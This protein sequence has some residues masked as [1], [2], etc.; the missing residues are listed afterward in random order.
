MLNGFLVL[1]LLRKVPR[2]FNNP[3]QSLPAS[4]LPFI[5]ACPEEVIRSL[6]WWDSGERARLPEVAGRKCHQFQ[7]LWNGIEVS[8]LPR[9][10]SEMRPA[11][12]MPRGPKPGIGRVAICPPLGVL[13]FCPPCV[14]RRL[15]T[16]VASF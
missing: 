16:W 8:P 14:A 1:Y 13:V 15:D 6:L 9:G 11:P 12:G 2:V 10:V 5:A 3:V 7:G 4:L